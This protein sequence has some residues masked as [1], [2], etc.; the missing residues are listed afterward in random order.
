LKVTASGQI[1]LLDFGLAKA[2]TTDLSGS[3]SQTSIFGYT[4]RY[5]PLEQIQD[6]GTTPQSDI[7]A[8]GATLYHL[9][10]GVKPPMPW[11]APPPWF[12]QRL[13]RSGQPMKF[14][15]R[16]RR[17]RGNSE[18]SSG[19]ESGRALRDRRGIS[20]SSAASRSLGDRAEMIAD[21]SKSESASDATV[22]PLSLRRASI[23][24]IDPF[25]SYSILKPADAAWL[26]P[27]QGRHPG[28]VAGV[29]A[30]V[31]I[32][33]WAHSTPPVGCRF[34]RAVVGLC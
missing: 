24:S 3:N 32:A 25:D 1:A 27:R 11:R 17:D 16:R 19:G 33:G 21:P 12:T 8:L 22:R 26:V 23:G 34:D 5:S 2:Q 9:L 13:I 20:W 6:Q 31:L 10:T 30:M 15:P 4:R 28:L 18:S 14:I 29:L 7:Y